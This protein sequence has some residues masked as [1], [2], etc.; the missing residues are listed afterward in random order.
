MRFQ[1]YQSHSMTAIG[2][3]NESINWVSVDVLETLR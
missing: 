1:L 2:L 3:K